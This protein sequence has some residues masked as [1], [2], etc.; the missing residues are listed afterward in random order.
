M[1]QNGKIFLVRTNNGIIVISKNRPKLKNILKNANVIP[2]TYM[3]ELVERIYAYFIDTS[4]DLRAEYLKFYKE[5]YTNIL[6][7]LYHKYAIDEIYLSEISKLVK[8][9]NCL[10]LLKSFRWGRDYQID[11]LWEDTEN[12][13]KVILKTLNAELIGEDDEN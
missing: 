1:Q 3:S 11:T 9:H 2:G 5:E 12:G 13:R 7:F 8:S 6:S 4:I 10:L